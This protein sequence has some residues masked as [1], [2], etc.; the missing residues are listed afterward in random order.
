MTPREVPH[1][2]VGCHEESRGIMAPLKPQSREPPREVSGEPFTRVVIALLLGV[3]R[4]Q[5]ARNDE[6]VLYQ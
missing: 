2:T 6:Y 5:E 4:T 3:T 1:V